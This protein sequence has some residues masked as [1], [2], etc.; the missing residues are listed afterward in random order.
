MGAVASDSR[1]SFDRS[2]RNGIGRRLREFFEGWKRRG[3][4][5]PLVFYPRA[6]ERRVLLKVEVCYTSSHVHMFTY[7]HL[8]IL[9][10]S[11]FLPSHTNIFTSSHL[12]IFTSSHLHIFIS[13]Y[14]NIFSLSLSV[15]VSLSLSCPLSRSLSFFFF[16]VLRPQAVPT[17]RHDMATLSHEM[18]FECQKL[19][20]FCEFTSAAATLSHEMMFECPILRVFCEIGWSW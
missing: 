20:V 7:S 16:S 4:C 14:L 18:R 9:K 12:H 15:S 8:H 11:I 10:S 19:R 1:D 6:S 17:R 2:A 13:S 3:C 5:F